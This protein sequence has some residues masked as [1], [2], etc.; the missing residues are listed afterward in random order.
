MYLF[1]SLN[2]LEAACFNTED[3]ADILAQIDIDAPMEDES[4][5]QNPSTTSA[6]EVD[7]QSSQEAEGMDDWAVLPNDDHEVDVA[8]PEVPTPL[9]SFVPIVP[10]SLATDD[11]PSSE[12]PTLAHAQLR[13]LQDVFPSFPVKY[14]CTALACCDY[15]FETTCT[16]LFLVKDS[17]AADESSIRADVVSQSWSNT[18]SDLPNRIDRHH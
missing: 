9:A 17:E 10:S 4:A 16:K 1:C 12:D 8:R 15:D 7:P 18:H 6:M 14:L 13:R 2:V 11:S 5:P 3:A